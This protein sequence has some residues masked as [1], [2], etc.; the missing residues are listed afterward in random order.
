MRLTLSVILI[1]IAAF[2][3]TAQSKS[4]AQYANYIGSASLK[5]HLNIIASDSMMGRETGTAGQRMA[6]EYIQ[7]QFE[8]I[9]LTPLPGM[10]GY[11][12]FYPLRSD[13]IESASFSVFGESL[14]LGKEFLIPTENNKSISL[15]NKYLVFVGYGIAQHVYNDYE[16]KNVEGKI[17]VFFNGEP[18]KNG[19]RFLD[20]NELSLEYRLDVAKNKGA[21]AAIILDKS[22]DKFSKRTLSRSRSTGIYYADNLVE[23]D[24]IPHL[25]LLPNSMMKLFNNNY[26]TIIDAVKG[27]MMLNEI[28]A[29]VNAETELT[30]KKNTSIIEASNVVGM[31]EGTSQKDEFV[32]ITAHYDHLGIV[33]GKIYNGADD[34]GSGTVSVIQMAEAFAKAKAEGNGTKKSI[35]FMTVSGEEKGLWGSEYYSNHPIV[36]LEKTSV[37]LNIDMIGRVDTERKK[38]DTGNYVYVVGHDKISSELSVINEKAN[39]KSTKL[40]LDYKFDDPNDPNR[41]YYRSDHYN[42]AR[43]GVPVLFFYDGMLKADYHQP[44]DDISLIHWNLFE[45]RARMI[46]HTAWEI[47]NKN[48][49]LKR[50]LGIPQGIR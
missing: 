5:K 21:V 3:S 14:M 27:D 1:F 15:Q 32:F 23:S 41:I 46:F 30:I 20:A 26:E 37:D 11:Q 19:K 39:S 25:F 34:D 50:D 10:G 12:Q 9:G 29:E 35:V 24:Y 18:T 7:S 28:S 43:K 8:K 13:S 4:A 49:L 36:P 38:A 33:N 22:I 2:S 40:T 48:D 31:L 44:S 45:K 17:V 47:A 6:A 42:F 16:N